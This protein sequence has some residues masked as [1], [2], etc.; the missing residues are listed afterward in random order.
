MF[1]PSSLLALQA[2]EIK[3]KSEGVKLRH[4]G[5]HGGVVSK[6]GKW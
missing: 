3:G 5:K 1:G 6:G 2:E 4:G